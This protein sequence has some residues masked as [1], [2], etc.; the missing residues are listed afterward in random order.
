MLFWATNNNEKKG[1]IIFH[2]K[3]K[4]K[5]NEWKLLVPNWN[6]W[7]IVRSIFIHFSAV[8]FMHSSLLLLC[9]CLDIILLFSSPSHEIKCRKLCLQ[10]LSIFHYGFRFDGIQA[11]WKRENYSLFCISL[12][13]S[14]H[15]IIGFIFIATENNFRLIIVFVI[16]RCWHCVFP[17]RRCFFLLFIFNFETNVYVRNPKWRRLNCRAYRIVWFLL[18]SFC[19]QA[20]WTEQTSPVLLSVWLFTR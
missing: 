12:L 8:L 15:A 17:F 2:E 14:G 1:F 5:R 4:A 19:A 13:S 3:R 9:V 11:H 16:S 6:K 10:N 7:R 20:F 18:F